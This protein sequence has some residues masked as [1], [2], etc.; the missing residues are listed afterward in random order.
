MVK[1]FEFYIYG[2]T[3]ALGQDISHDRLHVRHFSCD[4]SHQDRVINIK[5]CIE[6]AQPPSM[7]TVMTSTNWSLCSHVIRLLGLMRSNSCSAMSKI[8]WC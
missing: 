8:L 4:F 3:E 5:N 1:S 7:F 6:S 2:S